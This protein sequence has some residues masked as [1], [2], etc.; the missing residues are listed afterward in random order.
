MVVGLI[1]NPCAIYL[2]R[3]GWAPG[4]LQRMRGA[5]DSGPVVELQ[6]R[7]SFSAEQFKRL[8]KPAPGTDP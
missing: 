1:R 7:H 2:S 6:K 8:R 5:L 3:A 4:A